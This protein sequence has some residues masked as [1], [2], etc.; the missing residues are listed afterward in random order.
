[1]SKRFDLEKPK[2]K[3]FLRAKLEILFGY[4][5]Q[6]KHSPFLNSS[7][8]ATCWVR[9]KPV[10][11]EPRQPLQGAVIPPFLQPVSCSLPN[12]AHSRTLSFSNETRS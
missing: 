9:H 12:K 7:H 8:M 2:F 3:S 4:L 10:A 5:R 1:M 11:A 6:Q